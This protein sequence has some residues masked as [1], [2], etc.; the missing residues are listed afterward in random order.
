M[1]A[2]TYPSSR[3]C[4]L[5]LQIRL[6]SQHQIERPFRFETESARNAIDE[7]ASASSGQRIVPSRFQPRLA[8]KQRRIET[9]HRGQ[10]RVTVEAGVDSAAL[11]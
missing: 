6:D 11:L 10:G 1:A 8:V 7:R 2:P 5:S 3:V 9:G 4:S